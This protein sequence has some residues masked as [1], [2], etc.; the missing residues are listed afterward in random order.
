MRF[1]IYVVYIQQD[2]SQELTFA[3][4]QAKSSKPLSTVILNDIIRVIVTI[5]FSAA[6]LY[7]AAQ[8]YHL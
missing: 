7:L 5:I 3:M 6:T 8:V 1:S 4:R 2:V